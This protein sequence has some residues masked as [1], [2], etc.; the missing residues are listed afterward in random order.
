VAR[1]RGVDSRFEQ[2]ALPGGRELAEARQGLLHVARVAALANL[3]Q[4][5]DLRFAYGGVVDV[6]DVERALFG[7][8]VLVDAHDHVL[9]AV[10]AR[11]PS[12]RRLF[13][14]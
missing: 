1:A 10:H 6:T 8:P 5:P 9:T 12:R 14:A 2:V 7:Q 4:L 13:D 11:L 3:G